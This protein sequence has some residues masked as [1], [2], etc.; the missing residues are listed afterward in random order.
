MLF[1]F[2]L[3]ES[4]RRTMLFFCSR[5]TEVL[6]RAPLSADEQLRMR[7]DLFARTCLS[8]PSY[9]SFREWAG[10]PLKQPELPPPSRTTLQRSLRIKHSLSSQST[11]LLQSLV[12][13][14]RTSS[15]ECSLERV[16]RRSWVT[17]CCRGE[18]CCSG[19][20]KVPHRLSCRS[21][22]PHVRLSY[23]LV[24]IFV[25]LLSK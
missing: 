25:G 8:F 11:V 4:D 13:E 16:E 23:F 14:S 9:S 21:H 6:E 5:M 19:S 20:V 17:E 3:L 10:H 22:Y 24:T 2:E 7:A 15:V 18:H 12:L 1:T